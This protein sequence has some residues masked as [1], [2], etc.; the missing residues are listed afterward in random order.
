MKAAS[1][2]LNCLAGLFLGYG[3]LLLAYGNLL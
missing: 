2:V 1:D 3:W